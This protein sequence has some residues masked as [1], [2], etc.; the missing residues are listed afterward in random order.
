L[1]NDVK[2]KF[3]ILLSILAWAGCIDS[4][5][6]FQVVIHNLTTSQWESLLDRCNTS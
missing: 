6:C 4:V 2:G 3:Q 5:E 1:S